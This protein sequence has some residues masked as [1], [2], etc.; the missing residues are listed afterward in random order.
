MRVRRVDGEMH[1]ELVE[2]GLLIVPRGHDSCRFLVRH[3][4]ASEMWLGGACG[5]K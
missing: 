2:R 5:S 3:A 1:A 4:S